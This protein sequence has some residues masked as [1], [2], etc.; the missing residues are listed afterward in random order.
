MNILYNSVVTIILF[1]ILLITSPMAFPA[2]LELLEELRDKKPLS[3]RN[4]VILYLF[5]LSLGWLV[6]LASAAFLDMYY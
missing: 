4:K 3:M 1:F 6:A 5:V 2:A